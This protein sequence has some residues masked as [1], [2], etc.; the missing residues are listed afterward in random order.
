MGDDRQSV[1]HRGP[2]DQEIWTDGVAGLV[3]ARLAVIDLSPAANQPIASQ[4]GYG[5]AGLSSTARSTTSPR[6]ARDL[7]KLGYTFRSRVATPR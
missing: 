4:D 1:R 7:E 3:Q 5:V 2:D 6:S